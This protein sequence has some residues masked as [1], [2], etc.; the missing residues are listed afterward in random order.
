MVPPTNAKFKP[1]P[2]PTE[3]GIC[4][5][6]SYKERTS[7]FKSTLTFL[8]LA[9]PWKSIS[10]ARQNLEILAISS[11]SILNKAQ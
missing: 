2:H 10:A 3:A 7:Y 9:K 4:N 11:S 1:L 6:N 8:G 5:R